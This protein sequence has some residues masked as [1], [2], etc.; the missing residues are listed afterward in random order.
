MPSASISAWAVHVRHR[1]GDAGCERLV[2]LTHERP[3]KTP[4][5]F[6]S[7]IMFTKNNSKAGTKI[8]EKENCVEAELPLDAY[9]TWIDVLRND[10]PLLLTWT[11]ASESL[12]RQ[13]PVLTNLESAAEK[14]ADSDD[15]P[16]IRLSTC[17][18]GP[19]CS[20]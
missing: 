6:K 16:S 4:Q 14:M 3:G 7:K 20:K 13:R 15:A 17:S 8:I 18:K 11:S 9:A 19:G 10:K 12:R 5:I 1:E 2:V